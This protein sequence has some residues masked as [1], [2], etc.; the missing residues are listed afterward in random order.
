MPGED[1]RAGTAFAGDGG[2]SGPWRELRPRGLYDLRVGTAGADAEADSAF[3]G[4]A[5]AEAGAAAGAEADAKTDAEAEAAPGA[6][7]G[8]GAGAEPEAQAEPE[9]EPEAAAG[10][11]HPVGVLR[12]GARD[13]LVV[14]GLPGAGKS[15]L[16]A[17]CAVA[18][19]VDSRHTRLHYQARLPRWI[20]YRLF[21]PVVRVAHLRRMR[22]G[23]RGDGP[24]AVQDFGAVPLV[25]AWVGWEARRQGRN[26]HVLFLD[27]DAATAW[28]SQVARGR[29]VPPRRFARHRTLA[30]RVLRRLAASG[31]PPRGWTSVVVLDRPAADRVRRIAFGEDQ[32]AARG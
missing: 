21:R 17:R 7:A 20:P 4:E 13:V 16:M 6:G 29:C 2:S 28:Q 22:A 30:A 9:P 14:A 24:L 19:L 25:R 15:T 8:A 31:K 5:E 10:H 27:V 12:Y 3:L 23:L 32:D 18:P 26:A 1:G 11:P